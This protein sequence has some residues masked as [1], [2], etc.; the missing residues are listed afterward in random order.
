VE[1]QRRRLRSA[2]V[3]SSSPQA[4][5]LTLT[6]D[7]ARLI[8]LRAQGF[9]GTEGR[10]GGVPGMLRRLGAVQ[11]DTISVL[12]RSHELV[13]YARLGAIGRD[14]IERAYWHP[15][16]ADTFEYWSHAACL[17]PIEEW[18]Y[19]AF[20]RRAFRARGLRWHQSHETVCSEVL[21][22]LRSEG[23][24]TATQL[25]GAKKGSEWWDWSDTKI[26]VEWLL[27]TGEVICS[28]R[29]G[30]RR[31]YDLPERVLPEELLRAQ[32]TDAECL[33]H[34]AAVAARAL[35]VITKADL[36]DYQR[37][38]S[39]GTGKN[40]AGLS[41][42]EA[43]LAAG[44]TPVS[45]GGAAGYVPAWADPAALAG[46]AVGDGA[47][48][49]HG[50]ATQRGRHRVTLL[51][52]FDSLIWDRKR[53]LRM[54][55]FEHTLEAY[56]PRAKRVHGYFTMPLL[57]GGRLV[58]RVDPAR[59]GQT[60]VARQLTLDTARAAEPMARALTDAAAWVGCDS[61]QLG[62]VQPPELE[63]RLRAALADAGA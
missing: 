55:G 6:P 21:A 47:A 1:C 19:Y 45:I 27:D 54:F 12:A 3:A 8:T 53:T 20:R 43:A 42:A 35:G 57:A 62:Q 61:V 5:Q 48:D 50:A 46:P 9:I 25:G 59:S 40:S 23:P 32:T 49:G 52:P 26:A 38:R 51:S 16:K 37:L 11:L 17:L 36:T 22:R 10:R 13:A 24:L 60:L 34:L 56:V 39:F 14:R 30:W 44:L 29:T 31:V 28:R 63:Q 4:P 15:R 33:I 7:E 58:G 2:L 18:P 41:A